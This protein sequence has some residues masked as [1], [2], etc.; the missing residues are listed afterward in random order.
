MVRV[1][2]GGIVAGLV[3][4]V[5][6]FVSHVLL[7]LGTIGIKSMPAENAVLSAMRDHLKEPG[8]Y[9]FPGMPAPATMTN[10]QRKEAQER[11]AEEI[12]RGPRGIL[13]YHPSG[14]EPMSTRQL[15]GELL[16]N[17]LG[18]LVAATLLSMAAG[19]LG[20]FAARLTFVTLLGL[21][22]SLA[23]EM[24]YWIWYG[25]PTDYTVAQI[26]DQVVSWFLAGLTLAVIIR[27]P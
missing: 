17:L 11:W 13:V 10:E 21:F 2:L 16:T 14:T 19:A 24:S 12:R 27:R 8:F 4:F 15:G 26:A 7:P 23:I 6:G 20:A 18:G 9:F 3:V 25:F 1:I 5:W 22:A